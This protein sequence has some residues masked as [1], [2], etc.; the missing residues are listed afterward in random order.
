MESE[1]P[2]MAPCP[3]S[4]PEL[5]TVN[6]EKSRPAKNI[7]KVVGVTSNEGFLV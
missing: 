4:R 2:V 3:K 6:T 7:A 5:E 1:K